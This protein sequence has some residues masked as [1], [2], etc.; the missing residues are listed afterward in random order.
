LHEKGAAALETDERF[1]VVDENTNLPGWSF[2][3][4]AA[5]C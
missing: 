2:I 1:V 4:P 5:N 3:T